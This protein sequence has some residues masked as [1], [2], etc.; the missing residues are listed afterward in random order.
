MADG[1]RAG[2]YTKES[3]EKIEIQRCPL[4]VPHRPTGLKRLLHLAS[5]ALS[6]LPVL[7]AQLRWKPQVVLCIAPTLMNAPGVL[8]LAWLCKSKRW[9]HLQDFELDAALNL[10]LFP[11]GHWLAR[12]AGW[13]EHFLLNKFDQV[14]TISERMLALLSDKGL[15]AEKCFLMPNWV[16]TDRIHPLEGANPLSAVLDLPMDML[17]ALYAGNLGRKQGLE[18]VIE[19]ARLLRDHTKLL[20]IIC[21]DGAAREE[22]EHAAEGLANLR[23]L[24]V[25]PEEKLNQLLNLADIHL[26]P[27]KAGAADL[28]MP[29]KLSGMLAS[30]RAVIA[31][32][33]A[34][35]GVGEI[36]SQIGV[37]VP[38]EDS[39]AL[40]SAILKLAQSPT[41]RTRL[42][43]KGRAY[44]LAHWSAAQILKQCIQRLNNMV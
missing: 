33:L 19:A 30:G 20:I 34:D 10:G 36:V 25:Q 8:F 3:W 2:C 29:S 12:L 6:S 18:T 41:E 22:L 16:D 38:P 11:G 28:V 40:A 14:S 39:A 13:S 43:R 26:L 7:M 44:A 17:V 23:F 15:P 9:L 21:G 37:L 27:Q 31:T 4:W 1:Y 5:F 42:G 32:V 24:P 35:T